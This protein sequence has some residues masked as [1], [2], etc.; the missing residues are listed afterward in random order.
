ME[1]IFITVLIL[2]SL[3]VAICFVR[4]KTMQKRNKDII[5]KGAQANEA[6]AKKTDIV[7]K[8]KFVKLELTPL[9]TKPEPLGATS[10]KPENQPGNSDTFVPSEEEK[11]AAQ[12]P[13]EELDEA[14]SD[15]SPDEDE[16]MDI[17]YPLEYETEPE[18]EESEEVA[19]SSQ[20][21]LATGVQFEYLSSAVWCIDHANEASVEVKIK[22]GETL[23]DIRQTDMFE[24]LVSEK[25]DRKNTVTQLMAESLSAFY[26][27]KDAELPKTGNKSGKKVPPEFD[28]RDFA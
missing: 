16:P 5:G 25:P 26:Q 28:I 9:A 12:V 11:L 14:F 7:G 27:K 19:G 8:S 20:A 21:A 6:N 13:P 1:K 3:F 23:Q 22:A 18:E 10:Q 24:Q 17:D 2:Y 4:I 15:T